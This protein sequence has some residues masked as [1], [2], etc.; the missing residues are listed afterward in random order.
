MHLLVLYTALIAAHQDEL[1]SRGSGW[2]VRGAQS[3]L[4]GAA[5]AHANPRQVRGA[6]VLGAAAAAAVA[7]QAA[8][9]VLEASLGVSH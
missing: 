1:F 2:D 4:L 9:H 5:R 6:A 7:V 3:S 8:I